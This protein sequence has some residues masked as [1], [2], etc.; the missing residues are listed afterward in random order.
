MEHRAADGSTVALCWFA[1]KF[2]DKSKTEGCA[3]L[4]R[5]MTWGARCPS[6]TE[7]MQT[8]IQSVERVYGKARALFV[9]IVDIGTFHQDV[10][11][12]TW[13]LPQL[14]DTLHG[15]RM[16]LFLG[17]DHGLIEVDVI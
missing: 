13:D 2:K 10:C 9:R 17:D 12:A 15:S 8:P 4:R 6:G 7:F 11:S 14:G 3:P 5:P 1:H 16:P